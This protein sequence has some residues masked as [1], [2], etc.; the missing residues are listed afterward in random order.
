MKAADYFDPGEMFGI[1]SGFDAVIGNPPYIHLESMKELSKSL[2]LPLGYESYEARG[3]MYSLFYE[4][5]IQLLKD[6]GVICCITS[7]KWMRAAY[8][9]SLRSFFIENSNPVRLI[10]F[11][12]Q[13]VF[14]ATVDTNILLATKEPYK[15][16]TQSTIIRADYLG[17]LSVYIAQNQCVNV[18]GSTW[19]ILSNMERRIKEKIE[20]VGVPLGQWDIK[21]NR[22]L[23]A[24]CN[25]AFIIDGALKDRLVAE[26]PRSAEIIRPILRGRDIKRYS[27]EFADKWVI[28]TFPALHYGIDEFPAVKKW[29][30][31]ADWSNEVPQGYGQLRLEQTGATHT[32]NGVKFKARKRTG[33]KW[34]ET[35]DQIGYWDDFSKQKIAWGK[36]CLSSQFALIEEPALIDSPYPSAAPASPYSSLTNFFASSHFLLILRA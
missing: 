13:K 28:A 14:D 7:N 18:F 6:G 15:Q 31:S 21:I 35:Q 1:S 25:E 29:L 32:V 23:L 27:Y 22:G 26:D 9:Q 10:D 36:L 24:G 8:G 16:S 3:D 20:A 2:Y 4:R 11:S 34:F 12:G 5:G 33:N 30:I 17:N 19:A